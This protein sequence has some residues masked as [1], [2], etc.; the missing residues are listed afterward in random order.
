VLS[1]K[2]THDLR[3]L[4]KKAF[5]PAFLT[6]KAHNAQIYQLLQSWFDYKGRTFLVDCAFANLL[7]DKIIKLYGLNDAQEHENLNEKAID[8]INYILKNY[9]QNI[10]LDSAAQ[11]FGYSKEYFSK[12]FKQTVGK[13]FLEFLNAIRIQK[14]LDM[15]ND[16][17]NKKSVQ[18][19]CSACGFN[20]PTSFYRHLKKANAQSIPLM[21]KP[22]T[23]T[24]K[25]K[26]KMQLT[27]FTEKDFEELY[28]FMKPIWEETY[29]DILSAQQLQ[30][31]LDKYFSADGVQ[32]YRNLGYQYRKIDD[33]GVLVFVEK[34]DYIYIDKLYLIPNARGKK[35]PAFVFNEL[36]AFGKDITLNV[37]QQNTRAVKCYLKNGFIIER[38][39]NIHLGD[40]MINCDYIMRKH[41]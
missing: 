14:A 31:L 8:L 2:Y 35:Y 3:E 29:A 20:N 17:K 37:N 21:E 12:F 23:Q 16:T 18:E 1:N 39:E 5:F 32:H 27:P 24:N 28:D 7:F 41:T 13:N 6:N 11:H 10:S 9:N 40:G 22:F 4:H 33:V 34:E 36:L 15:L 38:T 30:F 26:A 19:I 25:N